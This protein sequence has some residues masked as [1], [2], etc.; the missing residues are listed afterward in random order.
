MDN[1]SEV[2]RQKMEDTRS[3]LQDKLETLEQHVVDTVQGAADAAASPSGAIAP[4]RWPG[5]G[6][7]QET[8]TPAR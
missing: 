3:S 7:A 2:A 1:E 4:A 6:S 8:L 5:R